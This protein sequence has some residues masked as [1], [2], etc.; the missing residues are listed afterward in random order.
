MPP[1]TQMPVPIRDARPPVQ[2]LPPSF[3]KDATIG[4]VE[5]FR[6][7]MVKSGMKSLYVLPDNAAFYISKSYQKE[8]GLSYSEVAKLDMFLNNFT[9]ESIW[10][11]YQWRGDLNGKTV[12]VKATDAEFEEGFRIYSEVMAKA[13]YRV[14]E[15]GL[16][17]K[18]DDK[19]VQQR[20]DI[21]FEA[22][23]KMR[24]ELKEKAAEEVLK[25]FTTDLNQRKQIA[26][27][28]DTVEG[29][30]A[31]FGEIAKNEADLGLIT[32]A[33]KTASRI[34]S[35]IYRAE[36]TK[37]IEISGRSGKKSDP[38]REA[39]VNERFEAL[40]REK[41]REPATPWDDLIKNKE[42]PWIPGD[43][44]KI[45]EFDNFDVFLGAISKSMP[46]VSEEKRTARKFVPPTEVE[47][48]ALAKKIFDETF[49]SDKVKPPFNDYLKD[50][51]HKD[52]VPNVVKRQLDTENAGQIL[53]LYISKFREKWLSETAPKQ[54]VHALD[55]MSASEG[56]VEV[57]KFTSQ[58]NKTKLEEYIRKLIDAESGLVYD[59]SKPNRL[60]MLEPFVYDKSKSIGS[61]KSEELDVK[62]AFEQLAISYE[63]LG[64]KA[65]SD[66]AKKEVENAK[67]LAEAS[68][69]VE[70]KFRKLNR[71]IK[72][73][74]GTPQV[75]L[76]ANEFDIEIERR[77]LHRL[78]ELK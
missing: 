5:Q 72:E 68:V 53:N 74:R 39:Q 76:L 67:G 64:D 7:Q 35:D 43:K 71:D 18:G 3:F 42:G 34:E 9:K 50:P 73:Y 25:G 37:T 8:G 27:K 46:K 12:Y 56:K 40:W 36:V 48:L 63:N 65:K 1:F 32:D 23:D 2:I 61:K 41:W 31:A 4:S 59:P 69:A 13:G 66:V 45:Q 20:C 57:P 30:S 19:V 52:D 54:K 44:K 24:S 77:G 26:S 58:K 16:T 55:V 33:R 11:H 62:E 47:I 15:R 6:Q 70:E 78:R 49:K 10:T 29:R 22:M 38:V 21:Y 14:T 75:S 17:G 60:G 51:D 28:L